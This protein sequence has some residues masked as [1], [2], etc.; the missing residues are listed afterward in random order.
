MPIT[1]NC[2][3]NE[4]SNAIFTESNVEKLKELYGH[5]IDDE[6]KK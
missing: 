2:R 3:S 4:C 6:N 1:T 5:I